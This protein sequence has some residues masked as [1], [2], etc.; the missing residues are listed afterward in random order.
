MKTIQQQ[1][2]QIEQLQKL[3]GVDQAL[4]DAEEVR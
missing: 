4:E 3:L 2:E 1:S